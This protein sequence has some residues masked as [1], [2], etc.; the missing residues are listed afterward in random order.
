MLLLLGAILALT[1]LYCYLTRTHGHWAKQKNV[2]TL[3]GCW[4]G[5]GHMLPS[6]LMQE[7]L[8][9]LA[10]RAY[11]EAPGDASAVGIYFMRKPMLVLRDP[12]LVKQV[13][14]S[15]FA[16][17]HH[18]G[19]EINPKADAI[20]ARNP[21]FVHD[22]Q[23]WRESRARVVGHLSGKK[24][25]CLFAIARNVCEKMTA[26]V[27]RRLAESKLQEYE[28]ELK[29]LFE[30][31]T[32]EM[33]ANSAFEVEGQCFADERDPGSFHVVAEGLFE[34]GLVNVV[35]QAVVFF[36]P[37]LAGFA[38]VRFIPQSTE[39]FFRETLLSILKH[40]REQPQKPNDFLQF[41][42][43]TNDENDTE[44]IIADLLIYHT[45]VYETSSLTLAF[46]VYQL[47]RNP[48]EQ[49][50]IRRHVRDASGGKPITYESLKAMSYLEQAV[51]ESLR[52]IPPAS[53]LYKRCSRETTL[54][55]E[56][57]FECRMRPGDGVMLPVMGLQNDPRYWDDPEA[58]RPDRFGPEQ[59]AERNRYLFLAFGEGPRMCVGMRLG[60]M[61]VKLAAATLLL[62]YRIVP[63]AKSPWPLEMD[64]SSFLAYAK[65][66]VWA[67]FKRLEEESVRR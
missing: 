15:D 67:R 50:K 3:P 33:V 9:Y 60:L 14:Q 11:R 57:G 56:D 66:G 40:R 19:R 8:E 28:P 12:D 64:R 51:Y 59:L 44:S 20:L 34:P 13:L 62:R 32:G 46:F 21:F 2:P 25:S 7:S 4:P 47:A 17:F 49:D 63:S 54:L 23:A 39:A 18:N 35:K 26:F 38:D 37:E 53:A 30:R 22:L 27:E 31:Y 42:L 41:V 48:E 45:D 52:L 5:V 65:G 61:L 6:L 16:S 58:F 36:L 24:L 29:K 43:D 10:D 1:C 55:G